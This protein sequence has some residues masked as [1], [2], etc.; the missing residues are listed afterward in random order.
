MATDSTPGRPRAGGPIRSLAFR[1]AFA[2]PL[3]QNSNYNH[4][5]AHSHLLVKRVWP[6]QYLSM[7]GTQSRHRAE[8]HHDTDNMIP[9]RQSPTQPD[10][11]TRHLT[12]T[13]SRSAIK[14]CTRGIS[15]SDSSL[16]KDAASEAC[17]TISGPCPV[18]L[19]RKQ[20]PCEAPL[21]ASGGVLLV[22]K[23]SHVLLKLL[24]RLLGPLDCLVILCE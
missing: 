11:G 16:G 4:A 1:T 20:P 2:L 22:E 3:L 17:A 21:W 12:R 19:D 23:L 9:S 8:D 13:R 7:Y 5:H 14:P 6:I 15:S 10:D 24:V 18:C